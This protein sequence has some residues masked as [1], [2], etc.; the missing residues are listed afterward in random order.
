M[1][2]GTVL[3]P[4]PLW[5]RELAYPRLAN[6]PCLALVGRLPHNDRMTVGLI[7]YDAARRALAVALNVVQVKEIRNKATALLAYAR[8]AGDLT[9]R[10]R[11]LPPNAKPLADPLLRWV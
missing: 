4:F 11:L 9:V 3:P 5:E 7:K 2:I 6:M 10:I 8:Q 1:E